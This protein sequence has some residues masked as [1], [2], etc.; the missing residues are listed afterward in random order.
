MVV[1][2]AVEV[3]QRINGPFVQPHIH[4]RRINGQ[5][6]VEGISTTAN[7]KEKKVIISVQNAPLLKK[8]AMLKAGEHRVF[9]WRT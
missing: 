8:S 6:E 2:A 4:P 1:V 3:D 9:D 7:N 5:R